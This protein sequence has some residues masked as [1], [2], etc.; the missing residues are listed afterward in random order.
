M[1]NKL[2]NNL[3]KNIEINDIN[4]QKQIVF[5]FIFCIYNNLLKIIYFLNE[6]SISFEISLFDFII[7]LPD[8]YNISFYTKYFFEE[9]K[10]L[11]LKHLYYIFEYF[12]KYL[13]P[14]ILLQVNEKYKKELYDEDKENIINYFINNNKNLEEP[15]FTINIFLDVIRKFI[16]RYLISSNINEDKNNINYDESLINYLD[17]KDLR[18]LNLIDKHIDLIENWIND[19]NE[20]NFLVQHSVC[21]YECL[22]E[23]KFEYD[24]NIKNISEHDIFDE[25]NKEFNF[26]K[27]LSYF[28]QSNSDICKMIKLS[29]IMKEEYFWNS[30]IF[31]N[32]QNNIILSDKSNYNKSFIYLSYTNNG[33]RCD[34]INLKID[35][36]NLDEML[37]IK[38]LSNFNNYNLANIQNITHLSMLKKNDIFCV[39]TNNSKLMIIKLKD[40]FSAIELIQKINLPDSCVNN[41]EIFN[42]D[43][44]LI[45]ANGKHILAYESKED[46]NDFKTYVL[47]K[48]I[49]LENNTYILKL[50]YERI[51]AFISQD[52][53]RIYNLKNYEFIITKEINNIKCDITSANQKQYKMMNLVGKNNDILAICSNDK[54]IYLIELGIK[55]EKS[56]N[57]EYQKYYEKLPNDYDN[58]FK[59]HSIN[60]NNN[61][62]NVAINNVNNNN[63]F[64]I[65]NNNLNNNN[66]NIDFSE[67]F[68]KHSKNIVTINYESGRKYDLINCT[69]NEC[70]DNFVSV[71]RCHDDYLLFLDNANKIIITLRVRKEDNIEKLKFIGSFK[72]HDIACF[73]PFGLYLTQAPQ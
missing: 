16:S 21:L 34:K 61:Y 14:F 13:F 71:I 73:T 20:F 8:I 41:I 38:N 19:L 69:L 2:K 10:E 50:D 32:I 42:N 68:K 7:N 17:K 12:E 58:W 65:D 39:G 47:K 31:V 4:I 29:S 52:I 46:D 54:N 1:K 60:N 43:H 15:K 22:S 72:C 57:K 37:Q 30:F 33:L 59:R 44:I 11:K 67:W 55:K 28:N 56:E 48:D 3:I 35:D 24:G 49:N 36:A 25:Q 27:E 53:I 64:N 40:N 26:F 45:V 62:N 9:N 18:P 51:V 70:Q 6:Q 23:I 5:N 63:N 66:K